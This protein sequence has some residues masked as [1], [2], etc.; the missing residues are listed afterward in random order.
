MP[1]QDKRQKLLNEIAE[2]MQENPKLTRKK[3][4]ADK[5]I[6]SKEFLDLFNGWEEVKKE[7]D[8]DYREKILEDAKEMKQKLDDK[9]KL[10]RRQFLSEYMYWNHR[11]ISE[12]FDSWNEIREILGL[13]PDN[14]AISGYSKK[15]FSEK[16]DEVIEE[17]GV[18][19]A[20]TRFLNKIGS[21]PQTFDKYVSDYEE[22]LKEKGYNPENIVRKRRTV[23]KEQVIEDIKE[24]YDGEY[25]TMKDFNSQVDYSAGVIQYK[26][27]TWNDAKKEAGIEES[28]DPTENEE[29]QKAQER[30]KNDDGPDKP[31]KE[32]FEERLEDIPEEFK[33][34]FRELVGRGRSMSGATAAIMYISTDKT[35]S[36]VSK[37]MDV[38]E[39][40]VRNSAKTAADILDVKMEEFHC[41]TGRTQR[42]SLKEYHAF[43]S[44]EL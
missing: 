12:N 29:W 36:Q 26:F 3:F 44:V 18:I 22:F 27:G 32:R 2:E 37:E 5:N 17:L 28:Y 41:S 15:Y 13:E 39:V 24:V 31:F 30:L 1:G 8:I 38:S 16:L 9:D 25:L 7:V 4:L 40:T 10:T 19:P 33:E 42:E 34:L 11:D 43:V 23:S 20:K 21:Y 35:Q 6:S 14:R